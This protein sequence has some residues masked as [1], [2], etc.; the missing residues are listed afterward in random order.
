MMSEFQ[1]VFAASFVSS[2]HF[3]FCE[4]RFF[5]AVV[6]SLCSQKHSA[7]RRKWLF[8]S[9]VRCVELRGGK[10]TEMEFVC[11]HNNKNDPSV[12]HVMFEPTLSSMQVGGIGV[13]NGIVIGIHS[14]NE[15]INKNNNSRKICLLKVS[16]GRMKMT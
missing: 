8:G 4:E 15:S 9:V 1:S 11:H 5:V 6:S 16:G 3:T 10:S 2:I 14:H 12:A 13:N 7:G